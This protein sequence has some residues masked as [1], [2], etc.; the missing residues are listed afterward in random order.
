MWEQIT[1]SLETM[2]KSNIKSLNFP[3]IWRNSYFP[4]CLPHHSD[5][6]YKNYLTL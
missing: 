1:L 6:L 5:L 4:Y 3:K 2:Q